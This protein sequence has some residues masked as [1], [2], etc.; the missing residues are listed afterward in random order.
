MNRH[1]AGGASELGNLRVRCRAHN[2]LHAEQTFGKEH[3]ELRTR[4]R[5]HPRE[6]GS[7]ATSRELA[8]SGLVGMGFRRA[9]VRR[10][11]DAVS[12]CHRGEVLAIPVQTILRE[13]LAVLT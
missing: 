6:R 10:A 4:E 1:P 13:A 11:L 7:A 9:E 12:A 3:V 5:R 8:A 2:L